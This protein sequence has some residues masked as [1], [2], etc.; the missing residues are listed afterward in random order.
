[1]MKRFFTL[2]LALCLLAGVALAEEP[3]AAVPAEPAIAK[4]ATLT[5]VGVAQVE[6]KQDYGI[7][8]FELDV[9]A[10]T[11]VLAQEKMESMLAALREALS[12]TGIQESETRGVYYDVQA[13]YDYNHTKY[14][15]QRTLV[16][17]SIQTTMEIHVEDMDDVVTIV[18]AVHEAGVNCSYDLVFETRDDPSAYDAA[19]ERAAQDALHKAQVLSAASGLAL[20]E[21]VS[22]EET[23]SATQAVVKVTYTV[24]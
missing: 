2:L 21:L 13:V 7:L 19:L 5:A 1:M 20:G 22:I 14:G 10:E 24:K 8:H 12:T 4:P 11:V 17:Y 3:H 9:S 23:E 15:E 6:T 16:G 18:A